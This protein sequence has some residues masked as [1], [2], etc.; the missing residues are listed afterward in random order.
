[1]IVNRLNK[2]IDVYGKASTT[3]ALGE[4][5]FNYSFVKSIWAEIVPTTGTKQTYQGN[6]DR[7]DVSHR[8]TIRAGAINLT[9][10]MYFIF[11]GQRY[12]INYFM[13][14]YKFNDSIEVFC[15]LV[16]E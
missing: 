2:R 10:D 8:F 1:M 6:T 15:S 13:P 5:D 9:N 14:N 7:A 16:I 3:N 12:D 11:K 4:M